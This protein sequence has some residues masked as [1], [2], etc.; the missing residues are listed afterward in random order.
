MVVRLFG[1]VGFEKMENGT[2][3]RD[4]IRADRREGLAGG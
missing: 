4:P 3:Q 2:R 1:G